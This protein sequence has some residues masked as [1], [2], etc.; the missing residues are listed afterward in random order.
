M[1]WRSVL[2]RLG[3]K[4]LSSCS[5]QLAFEWQSSSSGRIYVGG[6]AAGEPPPKLGGAAEDRDTDPSGVVH[7]D[8]VD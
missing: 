5:R 2:R 7:E 8:D 6:R 3:W 1:T 4:L